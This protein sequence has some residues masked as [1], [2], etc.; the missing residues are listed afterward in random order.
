MEIIL[1]LLLGVGVG[2]FGSLVGLGG[3]IICVPIFIFFLSEGGIFQYF[4]TAASI[5]GTSL[6]IVM[7]NAASGTFA[8][9]KQG[10]IYLPAALPFALAT[11][12]GA[13]LGSYIVDNFTGKQLNFYFGAFLLIIAII[14][15][16]NNMYTKKADVLKIPPEFKFNKKLGICSS[17]GVGF[18]SS[19]FGIGGGVIHVPIMVYL[20]NFPVHIATATSTFILAICSMFGVV[21]HLFL[22]HIVWIPAISISIGAAV[23]AQIGAKISKK[24]KSK[25][26]LTLLS[27]SM[28]ALGLK[29]MIGS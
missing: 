28:F 13:F 14:M 26:I 18:L 15:Y 8:Y 24:T 11:L 2:T 22:N 10:R 7:I 17:L 25:I 16:L 29:L 23:G 19:M 1:F 5:V 21:S 3:G 20:L 6:F 12:P 4:H 9:L 27:I